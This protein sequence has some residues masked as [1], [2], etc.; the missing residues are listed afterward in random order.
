MASRNWF[1][2]EDSADKRSA[3]RRRKLRRRPSLENLEQR[4]VA[5]ANWHNPQLPFDVTADQVVTALD[6][7]AL[8]NYLQNASYTPVAPQLPLCEANLFYDVNN[9]LLVTAADLQLVEDF[10]AGQIMH[11]PQDGAVTPGSGAVFVLSTSLAATVPATPTGSSITVSA[12][13]SPAAVNAAVNTY[14][15]DRAIQAGVAHLAGILDRDNGN[16]PFF[17]AWALTQAQAQSYGDPANG[18]GATAHMAFDRHFVSNVAGK[19]LYAL[20]VGSQATG[21]SVPAEAYAALKTFVVKSLHKPRNLNWSDTTPANQMVTGIPADPAAYGSQ[22]F[23]VNF[24]F[25]M[26]AGLRGA[27]GLAAFGPDA[28]ATIPG[29]TWSARHVFEQSV[30]NI[31][32]Y[33]VYQ[34]TIGGTRVYNWEQ[35]RYQLALRG[36]DTNTG[37]LATELKSNWTGLWSNWV[38]PFLVSDVVDYYEATGHQASLELAK[39]LRDRT[40][41]QRFPLTA[42]NISSYGHLYE[43]VGEMNAYSRLALVLGDADMMQRV[44]VRYEALRQQ[45]FG[46][47]GWTPEWLGK[48]SDVGDASNTAELIETALNFAQFGWT[49]YY[50]DVE[51]FTRGH[52]LP[53]QLLDTGFVVNNANPTSD[54]QRDVANRL[55]GAFGFPAPYGHVAKKNPYYTGGYFTG[56]TASAVAT[57]TEVKKATYAFRGGVHEINLLFDVDNAQIKVVSPYPNGGKLLIT[58]KTAGDVRLRL[59]AWADR[60]AVATSLLQQ[61][62]TYEMAADAVLIHPNANGAKFYVAM[63]LAESR[64]SETI[65]GREVTYLW[66]GDGIAAMSGMGT[67]MPFFPEVPPTLPQPE[68]VSPIEATSV[69]ATSDASGRILIAWQAGPQLPAAY[70]V[71]I[72]EGTT[73]PAA[74]ASSIDAGL[75]AFYV[76]TGLKASTTYAVRVSARSAAGQITSGVTTNVATLATETVNTYSIDRAIAAGLQHLAS[77]QDAGNGNLPFFLV[78]ALTQSQAQQYG[79]SAA[80]RG[81][82]AHM[83]FDRHFVSNVAGRAL[84]ALLLGSQSIGA[85]V[86]TAVFESLKQTVLKTLHKPRNGNWNDPD[87]AN[88]MVTGLAADPRAYGSQQFDFNLLFN[89]GAGMLGALGLGALAP[90]QLDVLSGY[91]WSA[92]HVFEQSVDNLRRYYVYNGTLGGTRIYD[93]EKFR[94]QLGLT[95]GSTIGNSIA[96]ESVANWSTLWKNWADP[97]LVYSLVKYHEATGH[98]PTLELA[99]ELRDLAFYRRFPTTATGVP[100]SSFA[101]MHEVVGEMAAYSRL[102]LVLG[103]TD[104]MNRVRVRYEA[105]R[106]IG[107]LSTGWVPETYGRNSD[108]GEANN[109]GLLIETAL[110]FGQFGWTEYYDD[111]ERF[112]RGQLLP[113][114]LLDTS[115]VVPN[116]NPAND[117]QRDIP[118]RVR[119]AFG[120]AAP[121]GHVATKNPYY[122]GG[123]FADITPGAVVTLSEVK[124]AAYAYRSGMHEVNLLFDADTD[125]I[126][127]VS[128]YP[129][130]DKLIV[131]PKVAGDVRIRLPSWA[132]RAGIAASLVAQGLSYQFDG[133]YVRVVGPATNKAFYVAMPLATQ[134]ETVALNGRAITIQWRGDSVA[135]MSR[136][137]TPLP[138]FPAV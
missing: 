13:Q 100:W 38:D 127:I 99:K 120:F 11:V 113:S 65:N 81:A 90:G 97:F 87:P 28:S 52:L 27:M 104:M 42:P 64:T 73:A 30:D 84:Y 122:T 107:F 5:T 10:L 109:T 124:R 70:L 114:Q 118:N 136:M 2:S 95:G 45:A 86:P 62:I 24:L 111:A 80:G 137:G 138:F 12:N 134:Q 58:P 103:D 79:D 131:T 105:L 26:G 57:L 41:Y 46:D 8:R 14:N 91:T 88:Q 129:H 34:Q 61:G 83:A 132:D 102:A 101:H 128:P 110:N 96:A 92:R 49:Q 50:Q 40:F 23:D 4:L 32:R 29:Y 18:R 66:R 54:G 117:G 69:A 68:E 135:A 78:W 133:D 76:A 25:N 35:F 72:G 51:R 7:S 116:T 3:H 89:V 47:T 48:N 15:L 55:L 112:T 19:A 115:F 74:S 94:Y 9:D 20:L 39:E 82:T 121:Y 106:N 108:V 37:N 75:N 31:R 44:Q 6:A 22:Q 43:V 63:P 85:S 56:I 33:Y 126:K 67:P 1:G 53:A 125:K 77:I 36:G 130:G 93:W 16:I 59:P 71:T 98:Q 123:Y 119:G 17:T 21:Q 60:N